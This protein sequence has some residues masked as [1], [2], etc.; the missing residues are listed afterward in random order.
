MTNNKTTKTIEK[1]VW[2]GYFE[3]ILYGSKTYN[4]LS[5][6]LFTRVLWK[7]Q[8]RYQDKKNDYKLYLWL[9]FCYRY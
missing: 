3:Q 2:I 7:S 5:A 9:Y 8:K 1:K 6:I 4:L